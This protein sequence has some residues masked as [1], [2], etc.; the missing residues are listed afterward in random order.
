MSQSFARGLFLIALKDL[1]CNPDNLIYTI[2]CFTSFVRC[3][4]FYGN[5]NLMNSIS[6]TFDCRYCSWYQRR[7]RGRRGKQQEKTRLNFLGRFYQLI[8]VCVFI[9]Y[10]YSR[11]YAYTF[12]I[13]LFSII[14]YY[15][16]LSSS[17][18]RWIMTCVLWLKTF[19]ISHSI[20]SLIWCA[21]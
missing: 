8:Q 5:T 16:L 10:N 6:N 7:A 18:S 15:F 3:Y 19:W 21:S 4:G 17:R 1:D 13:L 12:F 11:I 14:F 20:S 2:E 9:D